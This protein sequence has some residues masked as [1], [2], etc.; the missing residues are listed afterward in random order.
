MLSRYCAIWW[1]ATSSMQSFTDDSYE[2]NRSNIQVA[3]RLWGRPS[4]PASLNYIWTV[5]PTRVNEFLASAVIDSLD[6]GISQC[7]SNLQRSRFCVLV[8]PKRRTY[9]LEGFGK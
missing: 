2:A 1:P 9:N 5:T 8:F 6:C 4:Q 3:N 7:A